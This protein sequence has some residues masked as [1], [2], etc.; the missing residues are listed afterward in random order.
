MIVTDSDL[1]AAEALLA[2]P[3]PCLLAAAYDEEPVEVGPGELRQVLY[4]PGRRISVR[5]DATFTW[6]DGQVTEERVVAQA[7]HEPPPPHARTFEVAG[8]PAAVWPFPQDPFLP[9]LA[10]AADPPFVRDLL[11]ELGQPADT[12]ELEV[13]AYR[14]GRRAV[15]QAIAHRPSGRVV[16]RPGVGLTAPAADARRVFLKVV[17]P[18]RTEGLRALQERLGGRLPVPACLAADPELGILVLDGLPGATLSA[19]LLD[20]VCPLPEPGALVDLLDGLEVDAD[21]PV[22]PSAAAKARSR[23][24]LLSAVLPEHAGRLDRFLEALGEDSP[25]PE[26]AVHGDFHEGQVLVAGGNVAGLLDVDNVGRGQRLDDLA[27]M[28]GR[29][30]TLARTRA[31]GSDRVEEYARRLAQAFEERTDPAE[32]RRRMAAAMLGRA[33]APFRNQVPDWPRRA[34]ERVE[35]AEAWLAGGPA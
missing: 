12:V 27:Q 19:C 30:W 33:T 29:V 15:V 18:D 20:P 14:P 32:L 3:P 25:Q 31:G 23:V 28:A 16:Y 22:R 26:V 34:L 21:A 17:A 8:A 4:R 7:R 35:L 10:R 13:R 11:A 1:P 9:G 2:S 24:E 5:Y 6:A